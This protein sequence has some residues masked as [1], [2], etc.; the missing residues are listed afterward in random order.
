M[1][2]TPDYAGLRATKMTIEVSDKEIGAAREAWRKYW[3]EED[4]PRNT[5]DGMTAALT[6]AARVRAEADAGEPLY[7]HPAPQPSGPLSCTTGS[8]RKSSPRS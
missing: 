4:V 8:R 3:C 1:T 6:A 2:T 5:R 7:A